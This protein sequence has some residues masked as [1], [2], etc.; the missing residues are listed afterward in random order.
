MLLLRS[1][2]AMCERY[3]L[4]GFRGREWADD[5]TLPYHYFA[6]VEEGQALQANLCLT[7]QQRKETGI[8]HGQ[9]HDFGAEH[10][11]IE[12]MGMKGSRESDVIEV[13]G[14]LDPM[15]AELWNMSQRMASAAQE[16]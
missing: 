6:D 15:L 4:Y 13:T 14:A 16:K 5:P 12:L 1:C 7:P 3:K 9:S 8:T 10:D 11:C 2:H